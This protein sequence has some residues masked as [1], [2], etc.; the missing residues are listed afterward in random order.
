MFYRVR[1][2]NNIQNVFSTT[3]ERIYSSL[4]IGFNT[5]WKAN[6]GFAM[7]WR[8]WGFCYIL[9]STKWIYSDGV[10]FQ[11]RTGRLFG[12]LINDIRRKAPFYVSDYRDGLSVQ[13]IASFFFL[14]FACLTP[15]VTFGGLLS[16]ATGQSFSQALLLLLLL[17]PS[18]LSEASLATPPVSHSVTLFR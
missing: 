17:F 7:N 4:Q 13:C 9:N 5:I 6:G 16:D 8:N 3:L 12:G 10:E 18:S 1:S 11:V 15:I 14:Y 2:H